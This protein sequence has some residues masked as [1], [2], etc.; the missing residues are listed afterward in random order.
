MR[1]FYLLAIFF[2]IPFIGSGQINVRL[3]YEW[4]QNIHASTFGTL[5]LN[6]HF[7]ICGAY[8]GANSVMNITSNGSNDYF[9]AKFDTTGQCV[10]A[11]SFGGTGN[12]AAVCIRLNNAKQLVVSGNFQS[13]AIVVNANTT[14]NN[15]GSTDIGVFTLDTNGNSLSGFQLGGTGIDSCVSHCVDYNDNIYLMCKAAFNSNGQVA[16]GGCLITTDNQGTVNWVKNHHI[17]YD[18]TFVHP[19]FY[20]PLQGLNGPYDYPT[21]IR[22]IRNLVYNPFDS[23]IVIGGDFNGVFSMDTISVSS[24]YLTAIGINIPQPDNYVIKTKLDGTI[25][26]FIDLPAPVY[27][28]FYKDWMTFIKISSKTNSLYTCAAGK[29]GGI[30]KYRSLCGFDYSENQYLDVNQID[31]D[32]S[33]TN[34]QYINGGSNTEC[35][36]NLWVKKYSKTGVLLNSFYYRQ[37]EF[38][39]NGMLYGINGSL[40][41]NTIFG[42]SMIAKVKKGGSFCFPEIPDQVYKYCGIPITINLETYTAPLSSYYIVADYLNDSTGLS[43]F[44]NGVATFSDTTSRTYIRYR[45]STYGDTL[46]N[47]IIVNWYPPTVATNSISASSTAFCLPQTDSIL[48]TGTTNG[49]STI[50]WL[51]PSYGVINYTDSLFATVP[52]NYTFQLADSFGCIFYNAAIVLTGFSASASINPNYVCNGDSITCNATI[53]ANIAS[54]NWSNGTVNGAK[55][56]PDSS[57]TVIYTAINNAGCTYTKYLN[58]SVNPSYNYITYDTLCYQESFSLPN[59]NIISNIISDT[60]LYLN[61]NTNYGCD[62]NFSYVINVKPL[63]QMQHFDTICNGASY[64]FLDGSVQN[65]ITASL[66]HINNFNTGFGCDSVVTTNLYVVYID[67]SLMLISDTA[68]CNQA[69]ASYQWF[70]CTQQLVSIGDTLPYY[71]LNGIN[72]YSAIISLNGCTDTSQCLSVLATNEIKIYPNPIN[73]QDYLSIAYNLP[74]DKK[75]NVVITDMVGKTVQVID[76]ECGKQVVKTSLNAWSAG[77]YNLAIMQDNRI[78]NIQKIVVQ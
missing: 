77:V 23:T 37:E 63:Y 28:Y 17:Y 29:S 26:T 67:T 47:T 36:D 22:T 78:F 60:T 46:V 55:F 24:T 4:V 50:L 70:N 54:Y 58:Y 2:G 12:D 19:M 33:D 27:N 9:V 64:T 72:A 61:Y 18:T 11:T 39:K 76:L 48:L 45:V 44:G 52:G 38:M 74:C 20:H 35:L 8:S 6:N 21:Y 13:N 51:G 40:F 30:L 73:K 75:I 57:G 49:A 32:E 31:M 1:Y 16:T 3:S 41:C 14:I 7:Y 25:K 71:I 10:W 53:T 68:W 42:D 5:L 43:N 69:N 62:S 59:G 34:F 65:N 15:M 56:Q 66:L